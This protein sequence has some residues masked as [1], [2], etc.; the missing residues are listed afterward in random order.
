MA[1]HKLESWNYVHYLDEQMARTFDP[2][3]LGSIEL[4]CKA[5]ELGSF[6]GAAEALGLTPASVSRSIGRLE[7][8]LGV[9]LF[10][11]TTRSVKLTAGGEL[12]HAQ[13]Q[14]ALEQIAEAERALTGQQA[15]PKGL[16]RVSVGTVYGHHRVVPLLPG[17]MAAFPGVE[18]ELNVSNRNVDFVEDG[19]DLAIRL[20]EPRDSRLVSRKLEEATVGIFGAPAYLRRR[21]EP[22]TL[23]ELRQHDLIQFVLPSTG[24]PMPWIL[25]TP[26][27]EDLDF[28]FRSRQR[29]HEDVLAGVGWA[30]AGGG[31]FQIYH[32][33]A[34]AAVQAG[35]LVEVMAGHGGRS[36]PFHVLYPQNRHLSARVRA[37][38]DYLA[39]AVGPSKPQ[40]ACRAGMD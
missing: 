16:V 40:P 17:F 26:E 1:S 25:R 11:R 8:R 36:R 15:E 18:V 6:T 39:E 33:V 24:R 5:A 19:Y 23:D 29:V 28:G 7:A 10:N 27:G 34:H 21:G 4:F 37:F 30:V 32:F 22:G 9:R 20:G 38:V 35:Q 2:V 14:Q 3:Q 31:L 12:Y 13:C